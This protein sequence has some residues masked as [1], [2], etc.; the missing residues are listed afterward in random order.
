MNPPLQIKPDS[1]KK[2]I[3]GLT[4]TQRERFTFL[5]QKMDFIENREVL[6]YKIIDK[7][8]QY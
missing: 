2:L 5:H 7:Y 8:Y 4:L 3:Q 1:S 6:I